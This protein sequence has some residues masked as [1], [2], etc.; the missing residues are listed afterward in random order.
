M[1]LVLGFYMYCG[2][3]R[4]ERS[5][6]VEIDVID[7]RRGHMAEQR[8]GCPGFNPRVSARI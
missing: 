6:C 7:L 4:T 3:V 5:M 8:E 1:Y 2:Y